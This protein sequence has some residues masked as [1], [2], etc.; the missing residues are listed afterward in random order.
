M[1]T[2]VALCTYNGAKYIKE[3]LNSIIAQTLPVDE[4]VIFD[5]G[6]TDETIS[7]LKAYQ[8][9]FP[10]IQLHQNETNLGGRANFEKAIF[11]GPKIQSFQFPTGSGIFFITPSLS[12]AP[13]FI[14][15]FLL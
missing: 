2:S 12:P 9:E 10:F 8:H 7:T 1:T 6:S 11:F 4:I 14:C 13:N 5:D 15:F 3:Q